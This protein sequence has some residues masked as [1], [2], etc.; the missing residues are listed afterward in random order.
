MPEPTTALSCIASQ[1]SPTDETV[2]DLYVTREGS[3]EAAQ[4]RAVF[5]DLVV[6]HTVHVVD[7]DVPLPVD[8]LPAVREGERWVT[9]DDLEPYLDELRRTLADWRRFQS[10]ACYIDGDGSVC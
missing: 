8:R 4:L 6:A 7:D 1:S 9:G 3:P 2:I 10:D 5:A